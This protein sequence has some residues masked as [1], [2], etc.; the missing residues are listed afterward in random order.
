MCRS[1]LLSLLRTHGGTPVPRALVEPFTQRG[2]TAITMRYG[3]ETIRMQGDK[4]PTRYVL[5]AVRFRIENDTPCYY[6]HVE[7]PDVCE[8]FG[9]VFHTVDTD[10]ST[11][12]EL[13]AAV[14]AFALDLVD[15]TN[16]K[17]EKWFVTPG[18][19]RVREAFVGYQYDLHPAARPHE[20]TLHAPA[21][22]SD[23]T[24]PSNL[25]RGDLRFVATLRATGSGDPLLETTASPDD[26]TDGAWVER[27]RAAL[28]DDE[29]VAV[30]ERAD[31]GTQLVLLEHGDTQVA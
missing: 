15:E 21:T 4:A 11:Q 2:T 16:T 6:G 28:R 22:D 10:F 1:R 3:P 19:P 30:R 8:D 25:C 5:T 12:T 14:T 31:G 17:T 20:I 9:F 27:V 24:R 26:V 18:I 13:D 29:D 7:T 23:F